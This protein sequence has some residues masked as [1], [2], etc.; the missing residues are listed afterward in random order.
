VRPVFELADDEGSADDGYL[1]WASWRPAQ[2][3]A[4]VRSPR[5]LFGV[6]LTN[7]GK[8]K[9]PGTGSGLCRIVASW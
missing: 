7:K 2:P 4:A 5:S 3:F 8:A 9:A 1:V 6:N